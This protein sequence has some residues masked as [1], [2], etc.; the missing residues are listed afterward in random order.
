MV[1]VDAKITFLGRKAM[2]WFGGYLL[3]A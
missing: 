3:H 1:F 2:G